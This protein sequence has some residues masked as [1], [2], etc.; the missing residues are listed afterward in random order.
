MLKSFRIEI[1]CFELVLD[2]FSYRVLLH[3]L[4]AYFKFLNESDMS[5]I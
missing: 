3:F 5:N 1:I 2:A 4:D